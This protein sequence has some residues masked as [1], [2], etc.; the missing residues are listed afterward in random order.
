MDIKQFLQDNLDIVEGVPFC[1]KERNPE[2]DYDIPN[3]Y[4][5]ENNK[6]YNIDNKEESC[7]DVFS[8]ILKGEVF[9]YRQPKNHMY[10]LHD[11][12]NMEYDK[13]YA[14]YKNNNFECY[15]KLTHSGVCIYGIN[16]ELPILLEKI[17]DPN[18]EIREVESPKKGQMYFYIETDGK[19]KTKIY[20]NDA[21][22]IAMKN[23]GNTFV[24]EE[25]AKNHQTVMMQHLKEKNNVSN[26]I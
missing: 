3:F 8:K 2:D 7:P 21:I 22:D 13:K 15:V 18:V 24:S 25:V 11:M 1:I 5:Y 26:N 6:I 19:I 12:F 10:E 14:L 20:Q 17:C 9:I 4:I 16:V 23:V